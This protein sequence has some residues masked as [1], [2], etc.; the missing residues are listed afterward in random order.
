MGQTNGTKPNLEFIN[1]KI[2]VA[3]IIKNSFNS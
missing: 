2:I 1:F 3:I